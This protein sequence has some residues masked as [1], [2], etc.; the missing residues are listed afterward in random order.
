MAT[1]VKPGRNLPPVRGVIPEVRAQ[2]A[3]KPGRLRFFKPFD[4]LAPD[5]LIV[6]STKAQI[7][8]F[9]AG[10]ELIAIG[11]VDADDYFL[12]SGTVEIHQGD[13]NKLV[14]A[15]NTE[16]AQR[17]LSPLRPS[18]YVVKAVTPVSCVSLGQDVVRILR[19]EAPAEP[20]PLDDLSLDVTQSRQFLHD[21]HRELETNRVNLPSLPD[22]TF[23]FR[24]SLGAGNTDF[25][26]L[27]T[28]VSSDAAVAAKLMKVAN[29]PL[30]RG[31]EEIKGCA[32]AISRIGLRT[33]EELIVCFSLRDVF[34]TTNPEIQD[35]IQRTWQESVD[36][37]AL[38]R[39][40]ARL[41]GG[42][43][44]ERAML[45]GLLHN[46][47]ALPILQYATTS[48][49]YQLKP[50]L[51]D[52][53]IARLQSEVSTLILRKWELGEDLAQVAETAD[54]WKYNSAQPDMTDI[55]IVARLHCSIHN[56]TIAHLPKFESIP[57]LRK[58][59]G[60]DISPKSSLAVL[61]A[62]K[63]EIQMLRYLLGGIGPLT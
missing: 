47:G 4:A 55:V 8:D 54:N 26:S 38:S 23:R 62:A 44:P 11:S 25:K 46:I 27:A 33:A 18:P 49:V 32:D 34:T 41:Q 56:G 48:P 35:K 45:A 13:D 40:I 1:S 19:A 28:I 50:H 31:T 5:Q 20:L 16:A 36:V 6:A 22:L 60:E 63:E 2:S 52:N 43:D 39:V 12:L 59:M 30:F 17:A 61:Q 10:A 51:I 37:A 14:V 29:S 42:F 24:A 15:A 57:A 7:V 3:I 58:L 21:F 9:V 53:A